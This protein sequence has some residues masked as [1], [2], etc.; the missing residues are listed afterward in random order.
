MASEPARMLEQLSE[1]IKELFVLAPSKKHMNTRD[2]G[3]QEPTP[4]L[5]RRVVSKLVSP[6]ADLAVPAAA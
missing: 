3:R 2:L 1:K 4:S 6:K 5:G